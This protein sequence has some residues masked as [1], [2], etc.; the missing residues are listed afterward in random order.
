[1]LEENFG[2]PLQLNITSN[3]TFESIYEEKELGNGCRDIRYRCSSNLFF[4]ARGGSWSLVITQNSNANQP[5]ISFYGFLALR[6]CRRIVLGF[7][8][9]KVTIAKHFTNTTRLNKSR[10][11]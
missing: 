11:K 6:F 7:F 10:N 4:D 3:S 5:T 2:L 8:F 9:L 1:M